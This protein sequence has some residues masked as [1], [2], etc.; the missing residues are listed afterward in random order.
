MQIARNMTPGRDPPRGPASAFDRQDDT[1]SNLPTG[2]R[3]ENVGPT[4]P[5]VLS[6]DDIVLVAVLE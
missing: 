2:R 3:P 6:D 4:V 5:V 1:A